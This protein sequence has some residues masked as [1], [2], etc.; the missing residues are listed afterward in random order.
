MNNNM[1]TFSVLKFI[2]KVVNENIDIISLNNYMIFLF[3]IPAKIMI[4]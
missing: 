2:F 3:H 4:T 1:N